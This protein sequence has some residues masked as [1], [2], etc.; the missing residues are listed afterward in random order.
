MT[1]KSAKQIINLYRSLPIIVPA[2]LT[3]LND[4]DI[5]YYDNR[6]CKSYYTR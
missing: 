2:I 5:D 1:K 3:E 4:K 6:G